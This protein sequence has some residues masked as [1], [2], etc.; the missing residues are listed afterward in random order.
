M[1]KSHKDR[2]Y[3]ME[4]GNYRDSSSAQKSKKGKRKRVNQVLQNIR[5]SKDY[6]DY[7]L[8]DDIETDDE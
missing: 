5:S 6:E 1:S 8:D 2:R 3:D 4:E 7:E